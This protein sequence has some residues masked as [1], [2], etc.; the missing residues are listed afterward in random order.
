MSTEISEPLADAAVSGAWIDTFD[1][2]KITS[3]RRQPLRA[4]R[5]ATAP[6]T[7]AFSETV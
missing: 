6:A 7:G 5:Q 1:I 3:V 2:L 4:A